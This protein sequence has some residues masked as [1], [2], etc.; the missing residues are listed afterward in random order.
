MSKKNYV[1]ELYFLPLFHRFMA[2]ND[3]W[4]ELADIY[5]SL[6]MWVLLVSLLKRSN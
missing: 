6:Q 4:R 2:D 3:A 5:V 1:I